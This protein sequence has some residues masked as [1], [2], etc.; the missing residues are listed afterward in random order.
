MVNLFTRQHSVRGWFP[1]KGQQ[2]GGRVGLTVCAT[3]KRTFRFQCAWVEYV[4]LQGKVEMEL[5][6]VLGELATPVGLGRAGPMPLQAPKYV[7]VQN[8][9]NRPIDKS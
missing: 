1:V 4:I 9:F 3:N 6:V 8:Y 2:M 5:E 7:Y